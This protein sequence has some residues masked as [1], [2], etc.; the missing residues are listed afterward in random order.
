ML[1]LPYTTIQG[2]KILAE[3]LRG[4]FNDIRFSELEGITASFGITE[5]C[6]GDHSESIISRVD[7]A[8]YR[9]KTEGKDR[10]IVL[11][12]VDRC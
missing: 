2:A 12:G 9:A 11:T 1:V 4:L 10:I 8:M 7:D 5:Y 6:E 3:K